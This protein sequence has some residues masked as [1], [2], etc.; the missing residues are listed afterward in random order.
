M[1]DAALQT[2]KTNF[3]VKKDGGQYNAYGVMS[4]VK[5][6]SGGITQYWWG[7]STQM[8]TSV[9]LEEGETVQQWLSS[10]GQ[11]RNNFEVK[12]NN[13]CVGTR[14]AVKEDTGETLLSGTS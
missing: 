11:V 9:P 7:Y 12:T 5:Q 14:N 1:T 4:V 3:T 8:N 6:T 2:G 10:V 13:Y